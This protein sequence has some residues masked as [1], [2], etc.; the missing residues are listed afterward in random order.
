M[1]S[2]RKGSS[3]SMNSSAVWIQLPR[4]GS[5][6]HKAAEKPDS[7]LL[8]YKTNSL[9]NSPDRAARFAQIA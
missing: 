6:F 7:L 2:I 3:M 8:F 1:P 4:F 9:T 5:W